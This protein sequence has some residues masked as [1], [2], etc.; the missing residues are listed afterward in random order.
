MF[1]IRNYETYFEVDCN[2][3][4]FIVSDFKYIN[5]IKHLKNK[6]VVCNYLKK[7]CKIKEQDNDLADKQTIL[8]TINNILEMLKDD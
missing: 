6:F 7:Y 8:N 1:N 2:N 3:L 4:T 5:I